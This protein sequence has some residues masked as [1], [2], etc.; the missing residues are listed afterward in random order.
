MRNLGKRPDL[1]PRLDQI[2]QHL[3]E[4]AEDNTS[5]VA[6]LRRIEHARQESADALTRTVTGLRD[7]LEATLAYNALRDLCT[8]V[9]GPLSAIETMAAEADFTDPALAAAHVRGLA[10]TL[11]GVLTR[12]GAEVIPVVVG[13]D[14][15]DP[16]RHRCVGVVR[17]DE[18]PFPDAR[19]HTVVRV[20]E[21]GYDLGRRQLTPAQVEI[22]ADGQ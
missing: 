18:S 5:V 6:E 3:E 15:Y 7:D 8:A 4:I 1:G 20:V 11:R 10:L 17:P 16:A 21:D 19:A 14:L 12:M 9:I 2:E 22:Q 13:H